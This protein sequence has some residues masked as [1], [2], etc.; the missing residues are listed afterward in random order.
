MRQETGPQ[1]AQSSRQTQNGNKGKIVQTEIVPETQTVEVINIGINQDSNRSEN[2]KNKGGYVSPERWSKLSPEERAQIIAERGN[3]RSKAK[4]GM[5][6]VEKALASVE[7]DEV[8]SKRKKNNKN[9]TLEEQDV[10]APLKQALLKTEEIDKR[11]AGE[12][13]CACVCS[14]LCC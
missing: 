8:M 4:A 3:G 5:V 11:A 9:K 10:V 12:G 1:H 7:A 13:S 6:K 14:G 2:N